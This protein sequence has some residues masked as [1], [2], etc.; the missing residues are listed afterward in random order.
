MLIEYYHNNSIRNP[1]ACQYIVSYTSTSR[2]AGANTSVQ[3][4][5]QAQLISNFK[6]KYSN[7]CITMLVT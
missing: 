2:A 7:I 4:M 6:G 5:V 1:P 3:S